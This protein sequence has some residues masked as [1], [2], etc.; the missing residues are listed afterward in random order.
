MGGKRYPRAIKE[1]PEGERPRERLLKHGAQQLTTA[2]LLGIL[3][4]TGV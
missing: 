3:C 2:E 4:R 1:W